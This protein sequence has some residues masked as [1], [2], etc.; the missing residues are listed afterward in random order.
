MAKAALQLRAIPGCMRRVKV[1][2][3]EGTAPAPRLYEEGEGERQGGDS[4]GTPVV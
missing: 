3:K 2:I 4:P 1:N